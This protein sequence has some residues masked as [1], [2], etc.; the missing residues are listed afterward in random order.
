MIKD[1]NTWEKERSGEGVR[2]K[3]CIAYV[4]FEVMNSYFSNPVALVPFKRWSR[5]SAK[6]ST[7]L[8]KLRP[9]ATLL[10]L[11]RCR[12]PEPDIRQSILFNRRNR[13]VRVQP[14]TVRILDHMCSTR[15]RMCFQAVEKALGKHGAH[16]PRI[17]LQTQ[18]RLC[19]RNQAF[20][21]TRGC[22]GWTRTVVSIERKRWL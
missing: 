15:T 20:K 18:A 13:D 7:Q 3:A 1:T 10:A 5:G 2:E 9:G 12:G 6:C 16:W 4:W 21:Y 14:R 8:D 22:S 17:T 19:L 11:W